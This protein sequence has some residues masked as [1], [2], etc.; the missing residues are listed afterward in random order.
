M[1][2]FDTKL[3]K[4]HSRNHKTDPLVACCIGQFTR[5]KFHTLLFLSVNLQRAMLQ[6]NSICLVVFKRNFSFFSTR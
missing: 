6:R 1:S 5:Y 3:I 4:L 2:M